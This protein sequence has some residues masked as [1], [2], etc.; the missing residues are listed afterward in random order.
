MRKLDQFFS[1]ERFAWYFATGPSRDLRGTKQNRATLLPY[2][3]E[4]HRHRDRLALGSYGFNGYDRA[5][6]LGHFQLT[7]RRRADDIHDGRW[8]AMVGK[9]ALDC[10]KS[11]A[12]IAL[13]LVGG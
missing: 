10:S 2:L 5:R 3:R 4:R 12:T 11:P 13:L 1:R 8:F 9:G 7:G 6:D